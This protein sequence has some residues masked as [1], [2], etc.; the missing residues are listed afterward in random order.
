MENYASDELIEKFTPDQGVEAIN[1][2][3]D[4]V[5]NQE[6]QDTQEQD[7]TGSEPE[8]Q[9]VPTSTSSYARKYRSLIPCP[10][11]NVVFVL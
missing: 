7:Y 10:H 11:P 9:S 2:Y 5:E 8:Q 4:G 6:S 3:F 1:Q